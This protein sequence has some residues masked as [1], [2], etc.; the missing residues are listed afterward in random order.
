[1]FV[2]RL[3]WFPLSL[4]VG[5][6][7][8]NDVFS[9]SLQSQSNTWAYMWHWNYWLTLRVLSGRQRTGALCVQHSPTAAAL[10]SNTAF[11]WKM[12]FSCFPVLL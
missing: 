9:G 8:V 11:E 1:M 7:I 6:V 3:F 2:T 5:L 10:S 12:W 4:S